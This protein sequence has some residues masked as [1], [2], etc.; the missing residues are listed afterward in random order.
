VAPAVASGCALLGFDPLHLANEGRLVAVVAA[1]D[2][3]LAEAV[4]AP[5]GGAWIGSVAE[6]PARV[7]LRT[8]FGSERRLLPPSGELL[9]RIC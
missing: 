4:L 6:G 1:A 3:P 5:G 7:V 9:P 2:R 8:P